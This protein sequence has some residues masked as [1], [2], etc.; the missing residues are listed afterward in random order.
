MLKRLIVNIWH[1]IVGEPSIARA[2]KDVNKTVKKLETAV[3]FQNLKKEAMAEA[4]KLAAEAEKFAEAEAAKAA[5]ALTNVKKLF[6][7]D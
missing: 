6:G 1:M 5:K 3:D 4:A 2:L 7:I